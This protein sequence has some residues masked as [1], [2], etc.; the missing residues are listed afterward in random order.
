MKSHS[1][2]IK[3]QAIQAYSENRTLQ[4]VANEFGVSLSAVYN[5]VRQNGTGTRR[6]GRPEKS[7]PGER[8]QS[9]LKLAETETVQSIAERYNLSRQRVHAILNRWEFTRATSPRPLNPESPSPTWH[10]ARTKENRDVVLSFRLTKAQFNKLQQTST[11]HRHGLGPTPF[12]GK[13][14][15]TPNRNRRAR[16]AR[17]RVNLLIGVYNFPFLSPLDFQCDKE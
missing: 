14:G 17:S 7:T 13:Q 8:D 9:I 1:D 5:W 2:K 11:R 4:S 6:R 15:R 3:K 16:V 12:I 10:A